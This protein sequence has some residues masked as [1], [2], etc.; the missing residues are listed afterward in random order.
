MDRLIASVEGELAI[1]LADAQSIYRACA[2]AGVYRELVEESGWPPDRFERWTADLLER[3]LLGG[4][5][6]GP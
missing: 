5:S 2:A 1:P 4:G 3:E 6:E